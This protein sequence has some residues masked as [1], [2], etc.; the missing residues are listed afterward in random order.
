MWLLGSDV[1]LLEIFL[2]SSRGGFLGLLAPGC[3][4]HAPARLRRGLHARGRDIVAI[5]VLP[6][7]SASARCDDRR[8]RGAACLEQ[9][10]MAHT[11]L[12]W[13]LPDDRGAP[14][15]GVALQ[16]QVAE[17]LLP[18]LDISFMAHNTYLE[19]AASSAFPSS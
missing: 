10:N 8:G 4:R 1:L 12:S 19:V 18:G 11:A 2:T 16:L 5:V 9:S 14:L 13:R 7:I 6:P 17:W 3:V 15:W